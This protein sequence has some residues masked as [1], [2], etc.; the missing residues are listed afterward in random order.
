MRVYDAETDLLI[1]EA[2]QEGD[3][4]VLRCRE[5]AYSVPKVSAPTFEGLLANI[6][7]CQRIGAES[8]HSYPCTC[9]DGTPFE[10]LV[11]TKTVDSLP[12]N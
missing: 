5:G 11:T 12:P 9:D 6:D 1:G 8:L 7:D 4:W 3:A 10:W 2:A